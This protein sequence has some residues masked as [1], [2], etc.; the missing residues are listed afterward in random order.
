MKWIDISHVIDNQTP[1]YPGDYKTTLTPYKTIQRDYYNSYLFETCLHTGT[2]IDM[3][4]HLISDNRTAAEFPIDNFIG[5]GVLLDVRGEETLAMKPEYQSIDFENK[6]V[7][8]YTGF[9]KNYFQT[10][11][12]SDHPQVSHELADFLLC[13]NIKMLGMDMPAPDY[14]PFTFHKALL[15]KNIFVL[16]NLANLGA[17]IGAEAFEVIALP[18]K[19]SAEAS[20]VRAVCKVK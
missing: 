9:D 3:P 4:M 5:K 6:I 19:I 8:L 18:L 10:E 14:P 17:L 2:H 1:L 20:L 16:E 7:L 15:K 13:K 12:F 11:Y